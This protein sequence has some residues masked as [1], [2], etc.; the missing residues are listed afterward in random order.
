[1]SYNSVHVTRSPPGRDGEDRDGGRQL[2]ASEILSVLDKPIRQEVV[3]YF[4]ETSSRQA[5]LQTLIEYISENRRAA[6]E[7]FT[8]DEI[9]LRLHHVHLPKLAANGVI[10]YDSERNHI[11]C[12][13]ADSV[14]RCR[15][16]I[17]HF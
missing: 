5:D 12:V 7:E 14:E 16:V 11:R 10:E 15:R 1:M 9:A 6:G 4:Y 3:N 2:T 13:S 17:Q 8:T